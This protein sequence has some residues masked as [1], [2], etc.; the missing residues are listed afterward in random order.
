MGTACLA[1]APSGNNLAWVGGTENIIRFWDA[2][3]GDEVDTQPGHH[4]AIGDA[5]F[6]PDGKALVTVSEDRTLVSGTQPPAERR[7]RSTPATNG[8]GSKRCRPTARPSRPAAASGP[9]GSGT[10][11]PAG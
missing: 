1:F 4:G 8:S 5:V 2:S 11:L 3:T 9:R 10:R 6:S 7:E